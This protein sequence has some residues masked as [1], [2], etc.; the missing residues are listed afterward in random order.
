MTSDP[1]FNVKMPRRWERIA[2]LW[3]GVCLGFLLGYLFSLVVPLTATSTA[4]I[5]VIASILIL[6]AVPSLPKA[7]I[8]Q[9]NRLRA[10][11]DQNAM[12]K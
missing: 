11:R 3:R 9:R 5:V 7:W 1:L 10:V 2:F 8:E 6:A 4:S 12:R